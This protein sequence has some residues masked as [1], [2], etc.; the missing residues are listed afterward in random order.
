MSNEW[1]RPETLPDL[2]NAGLISLDTETDDRR[3]QADKGPGWATHESK[4]VGISIAHRANGAIQSAY[5]PIAHPD[6]DNFP[7]EQVFQCLRDH[8]A[9]GVR[10]VTQ[11]GLYDW[12][13][14]RAEA[15][16]KMPAADRLEEIGALAT[17]LDENR[18]SYSLDSLCDWRNIAG[19]SEAALRAAVKT[20]FGIECGTRKN[21]PQAYIGRLPAQFVGAYAEADAAQ[22]LALYENLDP[23][24]DKQGLRE[25]YR[26]EVGLLPL[27]L[28]MR[29]RGIRVDLAAAERNRNSL[30][31]KRDAKLAEL[32]DK[33]GITAVDMEDLFNV[34][35]LAKTCDRFGIAYPRTPTGKPS[36]TS[37]ASSLGWMKQHPHWFPPAVVRIKE[38]HGAATKFLENYVLGH[39]V[40]GRI[41]ADIHPHRSDDGGT[42]SFRMSYSHPPLQ[43]MASHDDEITPLVRSC[44]QPE[45]GEAWAT[46]DYSQ[47]EFRL[48]VAEA[49]ARGLT[50]ARE[51]A[52]R[53]RLDPATDFHALVAE[54]T[55]LERKDAKTANFG[56]SY[57][58][59]AKKF[60]ALIGKSEIEALVIMD[61]YDRALPFVH[62][63]AVSCQHQAEHDSYLTLCDGARRHYNQ[64]EACYIEWGPGPLAPCSLDEAQRRVR[65]PSHPWFSANLQRA[66][67]YF[68]MNALI[69]GNGARQVKRWMLHCYQAGH[70]PLLMVHDSLEFS[71]SSPEQAEHVAQLGREAM[72]FSVPMQVDV[73]YGRTWADAKHSWAELPA[74]VAPDTSTVIYQP[75]PPILATQRT[76]LLA[77][78]AEDFP[79]LG[80]FIAM[81][82]ERDQILR[83]RTAGQAY[84]WTD[85]PILGRWSFTN[86]S[87]AQDKHTV[88][89]WDNWCRPHADD[90]ELWFAMVIARLTNRI[91]TWEA[92]GYPVP[93]DSAHFVATMSRRPKGKAYGSA[94][95]IPAFQGDTRPK[96]ETQAETFTRMWNDRE[97]LRPR[98][99]ML[100]AQFVQ[101]LE[102]YRGIGQFLAWQIAADTKPFSALRTAPDFH[103]AAGSGPGS[104]LGMDFLMERIHNA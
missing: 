27:V 31:I 6:S 16:I 25:V 36:F 64:W 53:Y 79:Y 43:Q 98:D 26:D 22:T 47:Q 96:Y 17:I 94:Y 56:K 73:K 101:G 102:S 62:E 52:E 8:V 44:F 104:Q 88:W 77:P 33:L 58:A 86:M 11:N 38:L 89:L 97:T 74:P 75:P 24:L 10:F 90:P 83:K 40:N 5:F 67:S 84:P 3:L 45:E 61:Q 66:G 82:A 21:K 34:S 87:R 93:W 2:R 35:W 30:L 1:R 59:G 4:I 42:K 13:G 51:A 19:K 50:G 100:V 29:L 32:A 72:T 80:E 76:S 65:T 99:G 37:A 70:V 18:V 15:G 23:E 81:V 39:A 20:H 78:R 14:L 103:T 60:A 55:G 28:E 85:D 49:E 95:V 48:L 41:H 57:R 12:G 7:R 71:V 54:L 91:E 68:A 46:I 69:Q 63:L 9:A 92:L